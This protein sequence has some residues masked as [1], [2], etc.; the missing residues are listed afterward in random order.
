MLFRSSQIAECGAKIASEFGL[1]GL[2]GIDF[3]WDGAGLWPT[4][5]NPRYTASVE[6][7]ERTMEIAL[8]DWHIRA[9]EA[10][11]DPEESR[12]VSEQ[13]RK[14]LAQAGSV[15]G[16]R[17]AAKAIVYAPFHFRTPDLMTL[18]GSAAFVAAGIT[19]AD[20]PAIDSPMTDGAPVCTLIAERTDKP[21]LDSFR[22]ALSALAIE[23]ARN[24]PEPCFQS[25]GPKI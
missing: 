17:K 19:I 12:S 16:S 8:L 9:C 24:R 1:R 11:C 13:F 10:H 20:R 15:T 25:P 2:F 4:E 14:A 21:G 23:F 5:V 22:Q 3:L 6:I 18:E 7:Y